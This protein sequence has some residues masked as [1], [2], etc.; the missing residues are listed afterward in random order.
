MLYFLV[1]IFFVEMESRFLPMKKFDKYCLWSK[2]GFRRTGSCSQ[3]QHHRGQV[4]LDN[5]VFPFST[6][7]KM[8]Q[9]S[10][11]LINAVSIMVLPNKD[12]RIL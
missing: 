10:Y 12:P 1:E 4:V 5:I 6:L 11:E 8:M 2:E 7:Q 3:N 9:K